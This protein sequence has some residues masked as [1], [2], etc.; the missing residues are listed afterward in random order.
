MSRA[1]RI[2]VSEAL[3]RILRADDHVS[4]MLEILEIL[5]HDEMAQLLADELM[6]RGFERQ[7][8]VLV[9]QHQGV[10]VTVNPAEGT[11]TVHAEGSELVN[12]AADKEGRV[13]EEWGRGGRKLAQEELRQNLRQ[14]LEKQAEQ[15]TAELQQE[16]TERLE[17]QLGSLRQELDQVVNRVTAEALKRKAAQIGQIKQLTEDPQSGSLTIVLEV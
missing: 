11:V 13:F 6:R 9:R 5:P 12:I 17:R 1:Y 7:G 15:K 2:K 14:N 10:S 16:V 3:R 4:T 8:Q